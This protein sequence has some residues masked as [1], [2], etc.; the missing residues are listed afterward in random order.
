ME[1]LRD[2]LINIIKEQDEELK[3]F[4]K[5]DSYF[6]WWQDEVKKNQQLQNEID[7]LTAKTSEI[8]AQTT[9]VLSS[10]E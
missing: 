2:V 10:E 9:E 5:T 6:N 1:N 4:R 8:K 3:N 7:R